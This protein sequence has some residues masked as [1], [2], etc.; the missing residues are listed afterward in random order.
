MFWL[1]F[2]DQSRPDAPGAGSPPPPG[3]PAAPPPPPEDEQDQSAG[4]EATEVVLTLLPWAI[5]ILLHAGLLL[6]AIFIVWSARVPVDEEEIIIPNANLSPTPGVP[7]TTTTQ[8]TLTQSAS[9][10]ATSSLQ[11]LSTSQS[12]AT[13]SSAVDTSSLA[14]GTAGGSAG[15]ASPF[16]TGIS[17]GGSFKATFFGTGGNA[18]RIVYLVDASGS[19]IATLPYVISELKRS[20]SEL[21][22]KQEFAVFFFNEDGVIEVNPPRM[23]AATDQLKAQRI[24]WMDEDNV[25]AKGRADP[26]KAMNTALVYRPQLMFLLSD[27]ITGKGRYEV[28]QRRLLDEIQ[29]NNQANTKINTIQYIYPDGITRYGLKATL[30]QISDRTGGEYKYLDARELGIQ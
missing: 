21:S 22:E 10:A 11:S 6:L 18:R 4:E 3:T 30:E 12:T 20:I 9:S 19:L 27:D 28:D 29:K 16:G 24:A 14:I 23:R 7:L 25:H 5:S 13:L 17:A 26:V 2:A 15:A 8:T 1:G